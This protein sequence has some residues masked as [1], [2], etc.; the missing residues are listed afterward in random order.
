M[1]KA[2]TYFEKAQRRAKR[3]KSPWNLILIPLV[4]LGV[5]MTAFLLAIGIL[6]IQHALIPADTILSS[7]T[8][9]GSILMFVPILFPSLAIGMVIANLIAWCIPPARRA[10]EKEAKGIKGA[11]F[12]RT[13]RKLTIVSAIL[14]GLVAPLSVLGAMNYFYVAQDGIHLN[15]LLSIRESHYSWADIKEIKIRCLAERRNLHLNYQLTMN[16]QAKV[17][18]LNEP[19]MKFVRSYDRIKPFI[20]AQK[21]IVYKHEITDRG[22]NRLR[23]R[24]PQHHAEKILEVMLGKS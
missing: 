16:D 8:R 22:V 4:I 17:D 15:P 21:D 23:R 20:E 10:F 9:V 24:Y 5:V 18:L 12:K 19:R 2:H 13:M 3:R 14:L 1:G 11:S 6:V 7:Y